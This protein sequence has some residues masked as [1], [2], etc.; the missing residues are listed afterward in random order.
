MRGYKF[1]V[2]GNGT[3]TYVAS[4]PALAR[5]LCLADWPLAE[6]QFIGE[7]TRTQRQAREQFEQMYPRVKS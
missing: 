7:E 4:T 2:E 3:Q 6:V 5:T 1:Q